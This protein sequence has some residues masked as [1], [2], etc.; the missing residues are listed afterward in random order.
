MEALACG[1]PVVA[2]RIPSSEEVGGNC[3]FYF[4]ISNP[5]EFITAINQAIHNGHDP[6]RVQRGLDRT[7]LFS[8]D[9]TAQKTLEAYRSISRI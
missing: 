2:S 4:D 6:D 9:K 7:K 1:C 8:W 5:N 3:L